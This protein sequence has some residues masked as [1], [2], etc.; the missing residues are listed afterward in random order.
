MNGL[1]TTTDPGFV[2]YTL[3]NF[4][5]LARNGHINGWL[6]DQA[7]SPLV[8]RGENGSGRTYLLQAAC[9]TN[10]LDNKPFSVAVLDWSEML[11]ATTPQAYFEKL[12]QQ[13]LPEGSEERIQW[14]QLAVEISD[15]MKQQ[16]SLAVMLL[17]AVLKFSV[18]QKLHERIIGRFR[19][20][21][22]RL[23]PTRWQ[24]AFRILLEELGAEQHLVLLLRN[25]DHFPQQGGVSREEKTNT[26][27]HYY[28]TCAGLDR[29]YWQQPAE[30]K[31]HGRV[32]FACT[33]GKDAPPSALD[34]LSNA[35]PLEIMV[36]PITE[37]EL[38][39]L[40][41]QRFNPNR[42]GFS[43]NLLSG[44]T[45]NRNFVRLLY[46]YAR[47]EQG[48]KVCHPQL[49]AEACAELLHKGIL[50]EGKC[51]WQ[52]APQT[53]SATLDSILGQPLRL[54]HHKVLQAV[55]AAERDAVDKFLRLAG[56]FDPLIPWNLLL[57]YLREVENIDTVRLEANLRE[58]FIDSTGLLEWVTDDL[59]HTPESHAVAFARYTNPLLAASL[60]PV[61]TRTRWATELLSKLRP[62]CE[63]GRSTAQLF[64][65]LAAQAG[66]GKYDS[67]RTELGWW[68]D[69]QYANVYEAMF[70]AQLQS[71]LVKTG[72]LVDLL[73]RNQ[74]WPMHRRRA[75]LNVCKQHYTQQEKRAIPLL[76]EEANYWFLTGQL[77]RDAGNYHA[78]VLANQ[79]QLIVQ[80][81]LFLP[82]SREI[83]ATLNN[84]AVLC[85]E[86]GDNVQA[87]L[88]YKRA[89][90]IWE[91]VLGEEHPYVA[92]SLNN[93][94]LLYQAQGDTA[95]ALPLYKRSLAIR[96]KVLG[97][98]H[99]DVANSLNNLAL[100]CETQS[101]YA[102]ALSLYKRSLEIWEKVR[103]AEHSD[104]A[105]S[106]NNL[107]AF[108]STQGDY[109][110]ALPLYKRSL[111][112]WE[113]SL[114]AEHPN[115]AISLNGLAALHRAR[116]DYVQALLLCKRSLAIREKVLG[117]KHPATVD[118][119][120]KLAHLYE[121]MGEL[122]IAFQF[123]S[124]AW[125]NA[126][127]FLQPDHPDMQKHE[128]CYNNMK[129]KLEEQAN[130][131]QS[132]NDSA[133]FADVP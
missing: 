41:G 82:E 54:Q 9:Q 25:V 98:E 10:T 29:E 14:S 13:T 65:H 70:N 57:Q 80:Q 130:Y 27:W 110:Q 81:K 86:Q 68:L 42:F 76:A 121:A 74:E 90:K 100:L 61:E 35:D 69:E 118:S 53:P 47:L 40:V 5:P 3:L 44:H 23:T 79:Q 64:L 87:L 55:P 102:Q 124:Q 78:A 37:E 22:S 94:A 75:I 59:P 46:D 45:L 49:L 67:M 62:Y 12:L 88:L 26:L 30:A 34:D 77:E 127:Q 36:A 2:Q 101:D 116:G 60:R 133:C 73:M 103:G 123:M 128:R 33:L 119:Y 18:D 56:L 11:S 97:A 105:S 58:H 117:K 52:L 95:Q 99:P 125:K 109:A 43:K 83:A 111:E 1:A 114:G 104:V 17:G 93:L 7:A 107:A 15:T 6:L 8:L 85:N 24:S 71:G 19:E 48:G 115:V 72:D 92:T 20:Q 106:L 32:L 113:K 51:G 63:P 31:T 66:K 122:D 120:H 16:D 108:F 21:K 38:K 39:T 96:E 50:L 4:H 28:D 131:Y 84:L 132:P 89:L 126:Q 129:Q 112:I 91:K